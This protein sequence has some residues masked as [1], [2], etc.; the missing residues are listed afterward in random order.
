MSYQFLNCV[1][2]AVEEAYEAKALLD[3]SGN[4]NLLADGYVTL[5]AALSRDNQFEKA[6]DALLKCEKFY[7]RAD[8]P[9]GVKQHSMSCAYLELVNVQIHLG[10]IPG[11]IDA[12]RKAKSCALRFKPK[13]EK[14]KSDMATHISNIDKQIKALEK[15]KKPG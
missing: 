9:I 7:M 4:Y 15:A 14:Q 5:G 2:R 3:D 1:P 10:N 6:K 12:A 8:D 11:A 13:D